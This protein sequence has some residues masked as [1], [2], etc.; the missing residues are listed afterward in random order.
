MPW[1]KALLSSE[2]KPIDLEPGDSIIAMDYLIEEE[3]LMVGTASGC[4]VLFTVDSRMSELAGRVEGGVKSI[5]SSPDGALFTVTTGLGQLL[6]MT[7]DWE[8]L[9]ETTFDPELSNVCSDFLPL[10]LK[11]LFHLIKYLVFS[12]SDIIHIC[13][14]CM[15]TCQLLFLAHLLLY[16]CT[17]SQ[18]Y[19][20]KSFLV[21]SA[22]RMYLV[23]Y[24]VFIVL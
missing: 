20:S 6:V 13:M 11:L 22:L 23:D 7:H 10:F 14:V 5:A 12:L 18:S 19:T 2:A 8:L 3:A 9:Y 4:L 24:N 17:K 21:R 1:S 15:W 16:T